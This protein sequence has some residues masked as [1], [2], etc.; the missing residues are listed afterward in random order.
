MAN[1]IGQINFTNLN[2]IAS[3]KDW[4]HNNIDINFEDDK[5]PNHVML[6]Y[7]DYI[8]KQIKEQDED[9]LLWS[10]IIRKLE[11]DIK[12]LNRAEQNEF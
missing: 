10:K 9:F 12:S 1:N 8:S 3:F 4:I 11:S 6:I 2:D 7:L 5:I